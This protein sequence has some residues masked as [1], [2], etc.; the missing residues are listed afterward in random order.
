M[1]EKEEIKQEEQHQMDGVGAENDA[2][3][4]ANVE[5]E[6]VAVE[7]TWEDKYKEANDKYVRLYSDFDNFRKRTIKEKADIINHA[8]GDIMKD[9]I[10]V[11][12][13]F[14]RAIKANESVS[15]AE[16]VKE[17]FKL[18]HNKFESLLL[19][20][21]LKP[22]EAQGEVFNPDLHEAIT[23]IPAPDKKMIGKVVDVVEKGYYLKEKVLRY[24]KV[25]VGQ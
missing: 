17:G 7:P 10:S 13:D 22:M 24:A 1:S 2:Q 14:E 18:V 3:N 6:E 20:K 5:V 8:A 11:L 4:D 23:N 19:A 12:D 16:A 15:D 21:G 9:F 25:V